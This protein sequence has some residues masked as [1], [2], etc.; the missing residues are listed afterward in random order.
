LRV[1]TQRVALPGASAPTAFAV[2]GNLA[3]VRADAADFRWFAGGAVALI[4]L[5]LLLTMAAQ[6]GFGLRPLRRVGATLARMRRDAA[7][8]FE[9]ENL[10]GEIVPLALQVNDLLDAHA[11]RVER[12]GNAAGDLAHALKTPLAALALESDAQSGEFARRVA[13]EVARMQAAVER[14]L[15]GR[16]EIDTRQRTTVGDVVR[17]LVSL[18]QRV[19]RERSL[20]LQVEGDLDARFAGRREDLEEMLGNLLDN[21]CKWARSRVLVRTV[22]ADGSLLLQV[23]DDGPGLAPEQVERAVQRGVRLDERAPGSGLG[24][25][26]VHDLASAHG[27]SLSVAR[28]DLGGLRAVLVFGAAD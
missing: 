5:A 23:D 28:S 11:L 25:A 10:P 2:A 7:V 16:G 17:A 6:V 21:A 13:T 26:I 8:R 14:H 27:G 22:E 20:D 1:A 15:A 12:A 18:M 3:E 4:A 9:V 19:H 24:L